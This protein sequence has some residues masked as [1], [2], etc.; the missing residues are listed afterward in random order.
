MN[1]FLSRNH[2]LHQDITRYHSDALTKVTAINSGELASIC[3]TLWSTEV[4]SKFNSNEL[5]TDD[6]RGK[7]AVMGKSQM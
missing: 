6:K 5:T 1:S 3:E 2:G 4:P 7:L